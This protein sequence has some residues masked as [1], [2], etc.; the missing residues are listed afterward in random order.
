MARVGEVR[1]VYRA[2]PQGA[3]RGGGGAGGGGGGRR[4]V[5]RVLFLEAHAA[6][7]G[8]LALA[9]FKR[10]R[11]VK[12]P[13]LQCEAD[14]AVML[15]LGDPGPVEVDGRAR[16]AGERMGIPVPS[17]PVRAFRELEDAVDYDLL[18]VLDGSDHSDCLQRVAAFDRIDAEGFY[19]IRVRRLGGFTRLVAAVAPAPEGAPVGQTSREP[20]LDIPLPDPLYFNSGT[21]GEQVAALRASG[22]QLAQACQGLLDLLYRLQ[23]PE[24]L[25]AESPGA[26]MN[27]RQELARHLRGSAT[28]LGPQAAK[29]LE[30]SEP[31]PAALRPTWQAG[32]EDVEEECPILHTVYQTVAGDSVVRRVPCPGPLKPRG[33]WLDLGHIQLELEAWAHDRGAPPGEMPLLAD[34]RRTGRG[35]LAHAISK[36]HG[37]AAKVASIL[38]LQM[39]QKPKGYWERNLP[40]LR[41]EL[42]AAAGGGSEIPS[43]RRL[44]EIGRSDLMNAVQRLGGASRAADLLE[45]KARPRGRSQRVQTAE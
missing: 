7:R 3:P 15:P 24:G 16:L 37:G 38:G 17:D 35:Q 43:Q 40:E 6:G 36:Y 28:G 44:R 10:I 32:H 29:L 45:M 31:T 14:L 21:L 42:A 22:A 18:L 13:A 20:S 33:Y 19:S 30:R 12:Y 9:A 2:A 27:L 11:Q 23:Y 4:K 5:P 25:R 26:G 1:P 39:R 41:A 34:L 8:A